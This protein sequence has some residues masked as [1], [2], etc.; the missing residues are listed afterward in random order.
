MA[1]VVSLSFLGRGNGSLTPDHTVQ[2]G[3]GTLSTQPRDQLSDFHHAGRH[4]SW[5][6]AKPSQLPN[7]AIQEHQET[8][9]RKDQSDA[10]YSQREMALYHAVP[11]PHRPRWERQAV[12]HERHRI[13][14][15]RLTVRLSSIESAVTLFEAEMGQLKILPSQV[16]QRKTNIIW[17]Y[18]YVES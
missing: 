18:L 3:P 8:K 10:A 17:Y 14:I 7:T 16:R 4:P 15:L 2:F 9:R 13:P 12:P 5:H 1:H 6:V 11:G